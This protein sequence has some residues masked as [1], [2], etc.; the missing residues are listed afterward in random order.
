MTFVIG[1]LFTGKSNG[2]YTV[3]IERGNVCCA[4]EVV[5]LTNN[6]MFL[7]RPHHKKQC[8]TFRNYVILFPFRG[9]KL[10]W[11]QLLS[12]GGNYIY[13]FRASETLIGY[14]INFHR[15]A[16][17][18]ALC[19]QKPSNALVSPDHTGNSA[20]ISNADWWKTSYGDKF[21]V[22]NQL[23]TNQRSVSMRYCCMIIRT[24]AY[25]TLGAIS[26]ERLA[27]SNKNSV[28]FH[29]TKQSFH[30]ISRI[31]RDKHRAGVPEALEW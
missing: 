27:I 28:F 9:I 26:D 4:A 20:L 6:S 13:Y 12:R 8:K 23:F 14:R 15:V 2:S 10:D 19:V 16:S 30:W 24:Y 18:A 29:V 1:L 5:I 25:C 21:Y 7:S 31:A 17:V 22:Y 3:H 11:V